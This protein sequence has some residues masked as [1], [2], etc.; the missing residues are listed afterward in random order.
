MVGNK[1]TKVWARQVLDSRGNPTVEAEIWTSGIKVTAIAPSGASTG[2]HEAKELRDGGRHY[3]G[4]G[5]TKAVDNVRERIA[6]KLMGMDVRKLANID[7]TMIELD[8]TDD[9]SVLGGNAMTAVSFA[10]AK[11]GA[12][13]E[14]VELYDFLCANSNVLPV[15]LM[16]VIN[17]GRH[18]GSD[19]KI[20]EFMIAPCGAKT[21]SESMRMGVEVYHSLKNVL[22]SSYGPSS[23]NVGDEGGFAP[24]LNS[25]REALDILLKAIEA[26][27][28]RP[29]KD[30]FLAIDAAA[31]E[32]FE[33]GKYSL[34]GK[35]FSSGEL[36]DFYHSII[37][38]YP[39]VSLEDPFDEE[40]MDTMAELTK[41][42]GK[43]VQIVGDDLFV[44][45]PKRIAMAIKA[46]AG[47]ATLLKVNQIGTITEAVQ[48]AEMSFEAGYNVMVSHRSGESEDTSIAD[49]AVALECGQIKT[50]APARGERTAKYNRLLRIEENLGEKARYLGKGSFKIGD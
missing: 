26:A 18:A 32:F 2:T 9:K 40:A 3:V 30:V 38:D 22:R 31:S 25:T 29:G 43:N 36:V 7:R 23:I 13:A 42:D 37:K 27:G 44:T 47:N 35:V 6:P 5:V 10:V 16:N 34:D 1:I 28:Y 49:I 33:D 14:G 50:G 46:G 24:P 48:A 11:A 17:G 19:L 12:Q 21:F 39:L 41:K 4:K 8:G 45:N 15:P 20:Q